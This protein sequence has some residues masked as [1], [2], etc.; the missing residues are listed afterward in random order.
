MGKSLV[1]S[2][3]VST[4]GACLLFLIEAGVSETPVKPHRWSVLHKFLYKLKGPAVAKRG[5]LQSFIISGGG[6]TCATRK[7]RHPKPT[8]KVYT[9]GL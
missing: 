4:W 3:S 6:P 9:P 8:V 2:D 7:G 5:P 1:F